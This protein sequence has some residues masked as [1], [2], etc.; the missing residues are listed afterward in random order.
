MDNIKYQGCKN[1]N[2]ILI[3]KP[4]KMFVAAAM[5]LLTFACKERNS[6]RE[7]TVIPAVNHFTDSLLS[8]LIEEQKADSGIIMVVSTPTGYVRAASG[9]FRNRGCRLEDFHKKEYSSMGKV[10]T[11]LVALNSGKIVLTDTVDTREGVYPVNGISL[12]DSSWEN[13]GYGKLTYFDAFAHQSNIATYM[14]ASKAYNDVDD[15]VEAIWLIGL[16]VSH[17]DCQSNTAL[18]WASLGYGYTISAWDMLE[19]FNGIANQGKK[20]ALL[21]VADSIFV[22]KERMADL[23]HIQAIKKIFEDKDNLKKLNLSDKKTTGVM[24]TTTQLSATPDNKRY[25]ME[26]CGYFPA[27]SPQYTVYICIYKQE[28]EDVAEA[29]GNAYNRLMD[30]LLTDISRN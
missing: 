10:A 5:L 2:T 7:T 16:D 29:L 19:F 23:K 26:L 28:K 9:N 15:F 17:V 13:G 8:G 18:V 22:E 24:G 21:P 25:K 4:V 11:W 3:M 1:Q 14:S 30:F 12:K 27:N 20:V 6:M